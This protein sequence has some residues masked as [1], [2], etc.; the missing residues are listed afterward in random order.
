MEQDLEMAVI[1]ERGRE[2]TEPLGYEG[3]GSLSALEDT[4]EGRP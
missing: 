2:G 4:E 3:P 1:H